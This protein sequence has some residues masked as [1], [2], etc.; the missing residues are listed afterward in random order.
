MKDKRGRI[1]LHRCS[2]KEAGIIKYTLPMV[3]CL[4]VLLLLTAACTN[5]EDS[6]VPT[7]K[8][9]QVPDQESWN[10]K[11]ILSEGGIIRCII[12][13]GHLQQF[14]DQEIAMIDESMKADFFDEKGVHTS[15]LTAQKGEVHQ[16]TKDLEATG[17]VVIIS[18]DGVRFHTEQI[19]WNQ[20]RQKILAPGAVTLSTDQGTETGVG[21]EADTGFSH[22]TMREITGHSE[23]R[24]E[25]LP[26]SK[27]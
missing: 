21:L 8:T 23:E 2:G 22:W 20:A 27:R 25:K 14:E 17:N 18:D 10:S 12:H 1:Q 9:A 6:P 19:F 5:T 7:S 16:K 15:Q 4:L 13:A 3:F 24:F 26:Q 11:I